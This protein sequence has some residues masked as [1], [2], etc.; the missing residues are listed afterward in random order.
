MARPKGEKRMT[1]RAAITLPPEVG[2]EVE[3]IAKDMAVPPAV[4]I[5]ILLMEKL[6]ERARDTREQELSRGRGARSS[7]NPLL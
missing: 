1:W 5:R 3:E 4:A 2:E 6:R 7:G